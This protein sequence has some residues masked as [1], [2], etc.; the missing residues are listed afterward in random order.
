MLVVPK[1]VSG[2]IGNPPARFPAILARWSAAYAFEIRRCTGSPARRAVLA[3]ASLPSSTASS[4]RDL[5][6]YWRILVFALDDATK[7]SQS[8]LGP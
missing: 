4:R 2:R 6:K 8:R 3:M 1:V 7:P 5:A